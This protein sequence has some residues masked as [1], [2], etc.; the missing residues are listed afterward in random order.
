MSLQRK[1]ITILGGMGPQASARLYELLIQHS[2]QHPQSKSDIFPHIVLR[3]L[4]VPDFIANKRKLA[5]A[6]QI[7]AEEV[8][9]ANADKSVVIA[10]ACNTA[11]LLAD[12]V[13]KTSTAPFISLIETV[14]DVAVAQDYKVVGLLATPMTIKTKLYEDIFSA[15]GID[16]L[17]PNDTQCLSLERMIRSVL[18][19]LSTKKDSDELL[20]IAKDLR[21]RGAES[22]IL[23]CTELPLVLPKKGHTIK[24]LDSL[25]VLAQELINI[26]Y[27]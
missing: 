12:E 9:S 6:R 7:F 19:G 17:T 14:A 4:E 16:C 2:D 10:I 22:V 3:S 26:Y 15:R 5:L 13:I 21:A 25:D 11:H 20:L 23:G 8:K 1:P 18:R 27:H 24:F